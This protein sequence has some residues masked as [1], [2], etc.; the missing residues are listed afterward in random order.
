MN[1]IPNRILLSGIS[2]I[3]NL[4][5]EFYFPEWTEIPTEKCRILLFGMNRISKLKKKSGINRIPNLKNRIHLSGMKSINISGQSID[6]LY[7]F[8]Y[9]ICY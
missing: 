6:Y 7:K 5:T 3:P 4:K 2:R 1:R 9:S 8:L